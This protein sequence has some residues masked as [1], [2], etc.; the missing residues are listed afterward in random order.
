MSASVLSISCCGGPCRCGE[1]RESCGK[2]TDPRPQH[3]ESSCWDP[4]FLLLDQGAGT[5][6][7]PGP[8][9]RQE[10]WLDRRFERPYRASPNG[11]DR[12][13]LGFDGRQPVTFHVAAH[14][15]HVRSSSVVSVTPLVLAELR[16]VFD[17]PRDLR[18]STDFSFTRF[19]VE[20]IANLHDTN[21]GPWFEEYASC[22]FAEEWRS[23]LRRAMHPV[24]KPPSG[25]S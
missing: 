12:L 8:S 22:G 7:A 2:D 10:S 18:Q 5:Q 13:F 23:E 3:I 9:E 14:S 6:R 17:R 15:I 4:R 25:C 24:A 11:D 16:G 21:G 19:L 20:S 1:E